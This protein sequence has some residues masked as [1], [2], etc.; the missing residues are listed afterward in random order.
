MNYKIEGAI[1]KNRKTFIICAILWLVLAIVFVV[2]F[3]YSAFQANVTG[4]FEI[5][6][7]HV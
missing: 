7:A 3:S 6:R 5:G 2:P 4:K 1:K